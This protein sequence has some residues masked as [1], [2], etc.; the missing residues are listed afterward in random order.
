MA[1]STRKVENVANGRRY[2]AARYSWRD[3]DL[4]APQTHCLV[5]VNCVSRILCASQS[6]TSLSLGRESKSHRGFFAGVGWLNVNVSPTISLLNI[7]KLE[8]LM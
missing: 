4:F 6:K 8:H 7:I 5:N 1:F 2:E 3:E